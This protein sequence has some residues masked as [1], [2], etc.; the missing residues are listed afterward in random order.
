MSKKD[1]DWIRKI[2][3]ARAEEMELSAYALAQKTE[4]A[5]SISAVKRFMRGKHQIGDHHL[6]AIMRVLKL[7]ITPIDAKADSLPPDAS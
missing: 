3:V 6:A 4:G 2:V 1:N 7:K 5:V